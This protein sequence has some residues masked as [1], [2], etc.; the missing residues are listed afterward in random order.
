MEKPERDNNPYLPL[1]VP[2]SY[3]EEATANEPRRVPSGFSIKFAVFAVACNLMYG[4]ACNLMIGGA[5]ELSA[6]GGAHAAFV[7]EGLVFFGTPALNFGLVFVGLFAIGCVKLG[8]K[9]L[10]LGRALKHRVSHDVSVLR[11]RHDRLFCRGG[12]FLL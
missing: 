1:Q 8:K 10:D 9:S 4:G 2:E 12:Q 11:R 7:A 3:F 6:L 5:A